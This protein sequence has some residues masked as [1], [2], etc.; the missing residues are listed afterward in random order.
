DKSGGG[1]IELDTGGYA[2]RAASMTELSHVDSAAALY[3]DVMNASDLIWDVEERI[4]SWD[5]PEVNGNVFTLTC[6]NGSGTV[7]VTIESDNVNDKE[8]WHFDNCEVLTQ[9]Y[10]RVLLNGTYQYVDVLAAGSA[11]SGNWIGYE[12]FAIS[13]TFL[14]TGEALKLQGREDR[15]ERYSAE[16]YEL[17]SRIKALEFVQGDRYVA[18]SDAVFNFAANDEAESYTLTAKLIGSAI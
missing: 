16:G 3:A 17:T 9:N 10:G 13:G 4:E 8:H 5:Q 6:E 2:D 18:I 12:A 7:V 1:T 14:G 11:V 15:D